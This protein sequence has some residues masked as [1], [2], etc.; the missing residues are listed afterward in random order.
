MGI[1]DGHSALP[2]TN[3]HCEQL[4]QRAAWL[5]DKVRIALQAM[6]LKLKD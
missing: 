3:R 1:A 2:I 4:R 5:D 6:K